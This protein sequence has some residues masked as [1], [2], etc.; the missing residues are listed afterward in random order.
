MIP[1]STDAP[2]YHWPIATVSVIVLNTLLWIATPL[3]MVVPHL[4]SLQSLDS[5]VYETEDE[6]IELEDPP[7]ILSLEYDG[8]KPWQWL[9]SNFMHANFF[10]LLFNMISL[11][12]FGLVVEGKVGHLVFLALYLGIGVLQSG[13][14]QIIMSLTLGEG[15]SLGASAAIFGLLGIAIIW[16]PQNEFDILMIFGFRIFVFEMPI[17]YFG[18]VQFAVETV[19]AV[20]GQLQVS[21]AVLHLMGFALG[22]GLGFVWLLRGWVDCES[23]DIITV[24][25]GHEGRDFEKERLEKEA[26]DLVDATHRP[27]TEIAAR[28]TK[29]GRSTGTTTVIA[30]VTGNALFAPHTPNAD[31]FADLFAKPTAKKLGPQAQ[32]LQL[33]ESGQHNAA[34]KLIVSLRR[35]GQVEIPQP[36]L[37]KLI[38]DLLA[39]KDYS[40]A[41]PMM[42]EHIRRYAENRVMLQINVSKILLQNQRPQKALQVLRSVDR[43]NCEEQTAATIQAL[44]AH[45]QKM[46]DNGVVDSK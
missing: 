7:T 31:D 27:S 34:L 37:A 8:I 6:S 42:T 20:M 17:M 24:L 22:I 36:Q 14:E 10:H 2:L 1:Y 16:A 41:I 21:S 25:K 26:Q 35:D 4:D 3:E 30:P 46:I 43:S 18:F 38:S 33:I 32:L 13:A 9:T 19:H 39:A 12:A 5:L 40:N 23:W 11:W 29:P 28:V 15:F 45:A 44:V